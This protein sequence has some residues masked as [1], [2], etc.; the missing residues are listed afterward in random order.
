MLRE[1]FGYTFD[2]ECFHDLHGLFNCYLA[3]FALETKIS[4]EYLKYSFSFNKT[5]SDKTFMIF[6]NI[7]IFNGEVIEKK[8]V[9]SSNQYLF[10][11]IPELY[12]INE[13]LDDTKINDL[14]SF[15]F[16]HVCDLQGDFNDNISDNFIYFLKL[17]SSV[18]ESVLLTNNISFYC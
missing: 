6:I 10:S 16:Y 12:C 7:K 3:Y 2:V 5:E 1:S 15:P 11:T 17:P 4:V 14:H 18:E 13:L 9:V 8:I